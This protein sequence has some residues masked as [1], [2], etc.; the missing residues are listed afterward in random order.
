[1]GQSQFI[2]LRGTYSNGGLRISGEVYSLEAFRDKI[3]GPYKLTSEEREEE[4]QV[5]FKHD[6]PMPEPAQAGQI[7]AVQGV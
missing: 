7:D 2:T 1:M 5:T 3:V 6:A 4:C